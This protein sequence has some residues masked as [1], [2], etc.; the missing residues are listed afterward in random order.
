MRAGGIVFDALFNLDKFLQVALHLPTVQPSTT[1]LQ[2]VYMFPVAVLVAYFL[3]LCLRF[4]QLCCMRAPCHVACVQ[5]EQ[6]DPF[7]ERHKRDDP[8]DCEWDRFAFAEYNRLAAEE[9]ARE[10]MELEGLS[11][12]GDVGTGTSEAPF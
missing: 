10:E 8:F 2:L 9:E 12:W 11:D 1:P 3:A 4:F 7:S 5:F 6:R